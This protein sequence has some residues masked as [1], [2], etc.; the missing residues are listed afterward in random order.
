M[1]NLF[2]GNMRERFFEENTENKEHIQFRWNQMNIVKSK[3]K[4]LLVGNGRELLAVF[5]VIFALKE[6]KSSADMNSPELFKKSR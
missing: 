4:D 6:N 3:V 1:T 2:E 5:V